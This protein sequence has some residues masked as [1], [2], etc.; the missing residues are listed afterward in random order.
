MAQPFLTDSAAPTT[1]AM[2][3]PNSL[4]WPCT[5]GV[6]GVLLSW[7]QRSASFSHNNA[8]TVAR[9]LQWVLWALEEFVMSGVV[10]RMQSNCS[11]SKCFKSN[12]AA[13]TS[14]SRQPFNFTSRLSSFR[15]ND[16]A[17]KRDETTAPFATLSALSRSGN[18]ATS[19]LRS[20][21]SAWCKRAMPDFSTRISGMPT[22]QQC[23]AG[24]GDSSLGAAADSLAEAAG[25]IASLACFGNSS[26]RGVCCCDGPP[27]ASGLEDPLRSQRSI[28]CCPDVLVS[29]L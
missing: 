10:H 16:S 26:I 18:A 5:S 20:T 29:I 12:S 15:K 9:N 14:R 25:C 13:L 19:T 22:S 11:T 4:N 2:R 28:A 8:S 6:L 27:P 17:N 21:M 7:R 3:Y 24:A 23:R 1:T